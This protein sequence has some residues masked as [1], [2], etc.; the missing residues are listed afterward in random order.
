M[1][2]W[3]GPGMSAGP[4]ISA[5]CATTRAG[6]ATAFE[7]RESELFVVGWGEHVQRGVAALAVVERFDVLEY[8]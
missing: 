6:C 2:G 3:E 4:I 1:P 7:R 8:R 5:G